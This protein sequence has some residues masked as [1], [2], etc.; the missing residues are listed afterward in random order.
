MALRLDVDNDKCFS[1]TSVRSSHAL[2]GGDFFT[3]ARTRVITSPA[4]LPSRAIRSR[5]ARALSR[6]GGPPAS[7]R[8]PA[9]ALALTAASGCRTSCAIEAVSSPIVATIDVRQLRLRLKQCFR[10][11]HELVGSL[12]DTLFELIVES[13]DFGFGSLQRGGLDKLPFPCRLARTNW[14]V[15]TTSRI[16]GAPQAGTCTARPGADYR[17]LRSDRLHNHKSVPSPSLLTR[18]YRRSL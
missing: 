4:C 6:L 12:D 11:P 13:L 10:R 18:S 15:R 16:S 8:R 3:N 1:N 2:V 5:Y 7:Q 17:S 9:S 14:W